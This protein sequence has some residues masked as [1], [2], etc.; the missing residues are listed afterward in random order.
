MKQSFLADRKTT[1]IYF[2]IFAILIGLGIGLSFVVVRDKLWLAGGIVASILL[3]AIVFKP[4]WGVLLLVFITYT[5]FSDNLI[6]FYGFPSIARAYI[7]FLVLVIIIRWVTF[8][9]VPRGWEKAIWPILAYGMISFA[10]AFVKGSF[11]LAQT[12]LLDFVKDGIIAVIITVLL[13]DTQTFK[14]TVWVL[15]II[16][17]LLG[18]I[19][20]YQYATKDFTNPFGGFGQTDIK[21]IVAKEKDYRVSG[22]V[23]DPNYYAQIMLVLIPLGF[24]RIWSDKNRFK[25]GL[26]ILSFVLS[27][28][29]VIL[30]FSRGGFVALIITGILL[31]VYFRLNVSR[32][33]FILIV[34]VFFLQFLPENYSAR[35]ET[36]SFLVPG[37]ATDPTTEVS[38]RGRISEVV[39]GLQMFLDNPVLGVGYN[40]YNIN[41]LD[42]SRRLGIDPRYEYRSAHSLYV[43]VAAETGILGLFV[44]AFILYHVFS[45][46]YRSWR[47]LKE[48]QENE[49]AT[50]VVAFSIGF[51]GYLSA[52]MF[53]HDA[54]PRYFWLLV[55]IAYTIPNI[56]YS[57]ISQNNLRNGLKSHSL[58]TNN[59]NHP[60]N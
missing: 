17:I 6:D 21:N 54:Y 8:K 47:Q 26:A 27:L 45:G 53:I 57:K 35:M 5:R 33:L 50:Q 20:V 44:Y 51:I 3:V 13:R 9:E 55:G 18:G 19:S 60:Y 59:E 4:Q 39:V 46:M 16:G 24:E 56:T 38:Y 41:Y 10:S 58:I 32:I 7:S 25:K 2:G 37:S 1:N 43:E 49:L 31:I 30:T 14:R 52:A 34:F 23:G 11:L 12:A 48:N 22:P 42:Y 40:N 28:S 29:A 36:L 15:L